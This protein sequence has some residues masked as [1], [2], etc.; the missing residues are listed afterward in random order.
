MHIILRCIET[1]THT[2]HRQAARL[3]LPVTG[4]VHLLLLANKHSPVTV[5]AKALGFCKPCLF[6]IDELWLIAGLWHMWLFWTRLLERPLLF[7]FLLNRTG[8]SAVVEIHFT[9][10]R[11]F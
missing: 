8:L 1:V 6:Q 3:C 9:C 7:R 5:Q 4:F 11:P 2:V 10:G